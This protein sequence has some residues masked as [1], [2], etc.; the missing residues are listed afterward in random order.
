MGPSFY[1][2]STGNGVGL[3]LSGSYDLGDFNIGASYGF[4]YGSNYVTECT[5]INQHYGGGISYESKH[6]YASVSTMSYKSGYFSQSTATI[7]LGSGKFKLHYENDFQYILTSHLQIGDNG[8]RWRTAAMRFSYGRLWSAGFN[9]FTGDP[10]PPRNR[11]F[12]EI[13]G[14]NT[15][16]GVNANDYRLG[17]AYI[18]YGNIRIGWNSESI[19]HVIQNRLAHDILTGGKSKHFERLYMRFPDRPYSGIFSINPYSLWEW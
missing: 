7:G 8:D 15:Y 12:S 11:S 18:G 19:R 5:G 16:D 10:G 4:T 1:F 17:A 13:N 6:F 3:N 14:I 9:L 2:S